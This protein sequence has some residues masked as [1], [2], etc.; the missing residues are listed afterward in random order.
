MNSPDTR[1]QW[2]ERY[3]GAEGPA[4][5]LAVLADNAHLLPAAGE[6]LDLACGLG[7]SALYL[8]GLGFHTRAWDLSRVAIDSLRQRAASRD[9]EAEE[10]DV[11]AN[12]PDP[13][14]F[15]VICVGHFLARPLCPKIAAALRPGGLLYYQTFTEDRVDG[16][17][18]RNP[19][20]R[21]GRNELLRLFP[22]L[23]VRL[24]REEGCIGD[25]TKGLRNRAQL[26]AQRAP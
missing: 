21:L 10:R 1:K 4:A 9:I 17:G 3:R 18:R 19:A 13:D 26:I 7:G 8:A 6:A 12:P 25:V 24:Y 5:P 23:V 2:D 22:D 11:L 20:L 14:R 15:D 16:A